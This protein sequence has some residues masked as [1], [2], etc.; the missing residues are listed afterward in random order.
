M[1]KT[2]LQRSLLAMY[3]VRLAAAQPFLPAGARA[4]RTPIAPRARELSSLRLTNETRFYRRL[5]P[6]WFGLA[7]LQDV[8]VVDAFIGAPGLLRRRLVHVELRTHAFV[9]GADLLLASLAH[10]RCCS[11]SLSLC[12]FSTPAPF[13]G[14]SQWFFA[15]SYPTDRRG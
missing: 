11:L 2:A 15:S 7:H 14:I 6:F 12:V 5:Q 3:I 13:S 9:P 4:L 8:V 10:G 1:G